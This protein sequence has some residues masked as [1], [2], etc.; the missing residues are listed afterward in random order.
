[1][2][3][4][5]AVRADE[6]PPVTFESLLT[7]M[8][9]PEILARLPAPDYRQLQASSYNRKSK[10]RDQPEQGIDGWFA[11]ED[12]LGFLRTE[13]KNGKREW[14]VMEHEGPGCL[15]RRQKITYRK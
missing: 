10:R 7:E 2:E 4:G 11:D 1:M 13:E 3:G 15:S 8:A 9:E 14:V 5:R 12:G 6:F